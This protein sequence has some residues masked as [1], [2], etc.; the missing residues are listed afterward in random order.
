[1]VIIVFLSCVCVCVCVCVMNGDSGVV[2][3]CLLSPIACLVQATVGGFVKDDG[4][5]DD[6][7]SSHCVAL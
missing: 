4:D 7:Q 3:G 2:A 5:G 1:M 6:E